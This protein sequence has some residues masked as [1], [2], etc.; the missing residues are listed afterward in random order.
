[1]ADPSTRIFRA[2][3]RGRLYRDLELPS[4]GWTAQVRLSSRYHKLV[5]R[6]KKRGVAVTAVARELLGFVRTIATSSMPAP[7]KA[8]PM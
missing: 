5:G 4:G 7:P 3:L 8:S 1:M 2:S 6:G